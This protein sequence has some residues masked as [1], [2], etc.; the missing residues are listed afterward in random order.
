MPR[1]AAVEKRDNKAENLKIALALN[2]EI[3][4][5]RPVDL[6]RPDEVQKRIDKYIELCS[7]NGAK[8]LVV[9][10][11][12]ALGLERWQLYDIKNDR[13]T[14]WVENI[15]TQSKTIIKKTLMLFECMWESMMING[16]INPIARI[17]LG[18]NNYGYRDQIDYAVNSGDTL[19]ETVDPAEMISK[20]RANIG[21]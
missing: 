20:Y 8:P 10:L 21:D 16:D 7:A 12:L 18:K 9:A 1:T 15:P 2:H 4:R 3:R 11:A 14:R 17:F 19:G 5:M 13:A 6:S